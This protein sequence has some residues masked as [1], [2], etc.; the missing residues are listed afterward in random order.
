MKKANDN[1]DTP[2][3]IVS[4][5]RGIFCWNLRHTTF[6]WEVNSRNPKSTMF[7]GNER[8]TKEVAYID[9]KE[10]TNLKENV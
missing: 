2:L 8:V 1:L 9:I 7:G 4:T 3:F 5:P 10:A 6:N